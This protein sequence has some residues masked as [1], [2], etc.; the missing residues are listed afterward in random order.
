MVSLTPNTDACPFVEVFID[1]GDCPT[2][3]VSM[4]VYRLSENR[5][6]L[7][8]GGVDIAPGVA[9][10]DYEVPFQSIAAYQAEC[11]DSSGNSLG[12]VQA[13]SLTLNVSGTIIHQPL[14]PSLWVTAR[15]R[16]D[17]YQSALTRPTPG[18]LLYTEAG[19]PGHWVGGARQGLTGVA[20]S[21]LLGSRDDADTMQ[22]IISAYE[23]PETAVLCIRTSA[24][25]RWPRTFFA[26]GDLSES[27]FSRWLDT[28]QF[29]STMAEAVS[30]F[31]GLSTPLLTY[32]D[33][34]ASYATYDAMDAA[35]A[36]YTDKDRDYS[37]AGAANP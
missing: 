28:F 18:S 9:A 10:L 21:L 20:V 11:F 31:P 23:Q 32:D 19:G 33:L 15:L 6:W 12:F 25:V 35:Y 4:R 5:T 30:P 7:V 14:D 8:R 26:Q 29:D 24:N 2:G 37:L 1:T 16:P 27:W 13:G 17:S 36:T 3:T 22:A 34:D